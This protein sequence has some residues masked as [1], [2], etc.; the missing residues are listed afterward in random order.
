MALDE[1]E[2]AVPRDDM[3][4]SL[5]MGIG[6]VLMCAPEDEGRVR[7]LLSTAGERDVWTIGRV[8]TGAPSVRYEPALAR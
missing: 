8:I 3:Y 5:N 4:R 6:L 2:G 7:D 1:R